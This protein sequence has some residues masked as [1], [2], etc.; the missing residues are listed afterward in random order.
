MKK[1]VL[2]GR[3]NLGQL[4]ITLPTLPHTYINTFPLGFRHKDNLL[5][6]EFRRI[7]RRKAHH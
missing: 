3:N 4:S 1:T 5:T 6:P 7:V 2:R